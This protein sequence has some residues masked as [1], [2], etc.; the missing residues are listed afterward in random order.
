[1]LRRWLLVSLLLASLLISGS[2]CAWL[3]QYKGP[4]FPGWED[5]GTTFRGKD[6]N[7]KPSG[8]LWDRRS[9]QIERSL[10]GNF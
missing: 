10:G 1:M 5:S 6:P 9:E 8:F 3:E 7:A 2:G 4:G